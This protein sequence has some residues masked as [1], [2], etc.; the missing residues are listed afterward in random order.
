MNIDIEEAKSRLESA[1]YAEELNKAL[2]SPDALSKTRSDSGVGGQT[3]SNLEVNYSTEPVDQHDYQINKIWR[4]I[5]E[6]FTFKFFTDNPAYLFLV[7]FTGFMMLIS[8]ILILADWGVDDNFMPVRLLSSL[9]LGGFGIVLVINFVI[10][11]V[12]IRNRNYKEPE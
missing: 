9:V 1:S 3:R 10:C 4:M 2:Y 5:K 11:L 7:A 6:L 12:E 8:V